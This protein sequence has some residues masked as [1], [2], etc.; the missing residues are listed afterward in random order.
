LVLQT[1][2]CTPWDAIWPQSCDLS[3]ATPAITG[4]ALQAATEVLWSLSGQRFGLCTVTLRPCRRECSEVPW[5]G[6]QW[7]A[8][9]PGQTYPLPVW[10]NGEWLNLTCGV[11]VQGCSCA[12]ISEAVLPAPVYDIVQV[13]LDG[14]PMV[15]GSYRIDDYRLLVR[16][17]GDMWPVCNNL[18]LA[19]TEV[20]TW[21]VTARFGEVP[22]TL[23]SIAVGELACEFVKALT[24]AECQLPYTVTSLVRQ[25]VSLTFD[26]PSEELKNGFTGLR[27]VDMFINTYNPGGLRSRSRVYDID[28]PGFRLTGT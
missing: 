20:G 14:S 15:T 1:G 27:F 23:A 22:T 11:C 13:K 9:W 16:T 12:T 18:A 4:Y 5:P 24:G 21:S 6:G 7:P 17:D 26:N 2:P 10:I 8:T 28:G 25:G 19:D 3:T